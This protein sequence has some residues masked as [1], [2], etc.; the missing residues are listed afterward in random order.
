MENIVKQTNTDSY[1]KE[2]PMRDILHKIR[3]TVQGR[4]KIILIAEHTEDKQ[5]VTD[6]R[7][8]FIYVAKEVDSD[9]GT[10]VPQVHIDK[11]FDSKTRDEHF[12]MRVRGFFHVY[13]NRRLV[14]IGYC[15]LLRI[16]L[17]WKQKS[18]S[19]KKSVTM[20]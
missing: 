16:R 10:A 9:G 17:H 6:V 20:A 8:K 14:K 15:H 5:C 12:A 19:P 7:K 2:A 4:G 3:E 11:T 1:D 13:R 18:S